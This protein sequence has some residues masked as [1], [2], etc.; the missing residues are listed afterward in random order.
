MIIKK[1]TPS[2]I[3]KVKDP[4]ARE[5]IVETLLKGKRIIKIRI[6]S[7]YKSQQIEFRNLYY[8]IGSPKA[9]SIR[10]LENVISQR[11]KKKFWTPIIA[12]QQRN[13]LT[14]MLMFEE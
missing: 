3:N 9:P 7:L 1:F 8:S 6:N 13:I 5:F 14:D 11:F 2:D 10:H 12:L 4:L